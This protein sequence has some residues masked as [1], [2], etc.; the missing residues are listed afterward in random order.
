MTTTRIACVALT[1]LGSGKCSHRPEAMRHATNKLCRNAF[2]KK[3]E[4]QFQHIRL[5]SFLIFLVSEFMPYAQMWNL[6]QW[7][8]FWAFLFSESLACLKASQ[9]AERLL[10]CENLDVISVPKKQL[11]RWYTENNE[12]HDLA[13]PRRLHPARVNLEWQEW[14]VDDMIWPNKAWK[15]YRPCPVPGDIHRTVQQVD[16]FQ[17][18]LYSDERRY[19][20]IG[21]HSRANEICKL[22]NSLGL[23]VWV[24]NAEQR[25]Q[26]VFEHISYHFL[27]MRIRWSMCP[28]TSTSLAPRCHLCSI[29]WS[30]WFLRHLLVQ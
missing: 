16:E 14:T 18:C 22:C 5:F 11:I 23:T 10:W 19:T 25:D 21:E 2:D 26:K 13:S 9:E 4:F 29:L 3:H 1:A 17:V 20:E 24:V 7:R 15:C 27:A 12:H 8:A 30:Q 28:E 6:C